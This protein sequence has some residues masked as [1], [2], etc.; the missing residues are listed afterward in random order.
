MNFHIYVLCPNSSPQRDDL[1]EHRFAH[2]VR[3]MHPSL[4]YVKIS[5]E[6][7]TK[8]RLALNEYIM[9]DFL[10]ILPAPF[11]IS[12]IFAN[13]V[14]FYEN[15][16]IYGSK[17]TSPRQPFLK[18]LFWMAKSFEKTMPVPQRSAP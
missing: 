8:Y 14:L 13:N 9:D 15:T 18:R 5:G 4:R 16:R 12:S 3:H 7:Y 1:N 11:V 10:A 2:M 6:K 17:L